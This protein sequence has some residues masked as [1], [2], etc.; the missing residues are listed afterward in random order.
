MR[1]LQVKLFGRYS[2]VCSFLYLPD[3]S[4]LFITHEPIPVQYK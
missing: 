1:M 2:E 4:Y 3:R